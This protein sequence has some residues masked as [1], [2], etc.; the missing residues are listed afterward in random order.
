MDGA[1]MK[2]CSNC[3]LEYEDKFTFCRQCGSKLQEIIEHNFCPYCGNRIE[4]EDA[5]CP[6]CGNSVKE[7]ATNDINKTNENVGK[8]IQ[9]I[10][11]DWIKK[12]NPAN[13]KECDQIFNFIQYAKTVHE[14]SL[15]NERV[16]RAIALGEKLAVTDKTFYAII[17]TIYDELN[18]QT[19]AEKYYKM[20]DESNGVEQPQLLVH[21]ANEK[22]MTGVID[23]F[24]TE[25]KYGFIKDNNGKNVFFYIAQVQDVV[26]QKKLLKESTYVYH[27]KYIKGIDYKG[28]VAA[29]AIEMNENKG[30]I[31]DYNNKIGVGRIKTENKSFKFINKEIKNPLLLAAISFGEVDFADLEV[32]FSI[33]DFYDKKKGRIYKVACNIDSVKKFTKEE[34]EKFYKYGYISKKVATDLMETNV[35]CFA[36]IPYVPLKRYDAKLDEA[37]GK[38]TIKTNELSS[39][40][41]VIKTRSQKKTGDGFNSVTINDNSVRWAEHKSENV[42]KAI[43]LI[44]PKDAINPFL[45]L[46]KIRKYGMYFQKAQTCMLGKDSAGNIVTVDLKKAEDLFIAAIQADDHTESAIANLAGHVYIQTNN[47]TKGLQLLEAYG[48]LLTSEKLMNMRI[49]L[50]DKSG[51]TEALELILLDAIPKCSKVNTNWQYM[52]KLAGIYYKRKAWDKAVFWFERSLDFLNTNKDSFTQFENFR[53]YC[54]RFCAIAYYYSGNNDL[55]KEKGKELLSYKPED[56]IVQSIVDGKLIQ[57]E[58]DLIMNDLERLIED[59]QLEDDIVNAGD[60]D[61]ISPFL[62][63]VLE[64]VNL[65]ITFNKIKD[66]SSK[67]QNGVYIGSSNDVKQAV[68]SITNSVRRNKTVNAQILSEIYIGISRIIFDTRNNVSIISGSK[69]KIDDLKTYMG[70]Y[71]RY[72]ADA[73]VVK[74][75]A[76][77]TIR[78]LYIQSLKNL[79]DGD[80]G[81]ISAATNMLI[82][83]FFV[84]SDKLPAE[85]TAITN[86]DT[87]GKYNDDYYNESCISA[88]DFMIATFMLQ[89]KKEYVNRILNKVYRKSVLKNKLVETLNRITNQSFSVESMFDFENLWNSAKNVYYKNLNIIKK[90]ITDSINEFHMVESTRQHIQRI[91]ELLNVKVLWN[92]D[93]KILEKYLEL[94]HTLGAT[95]EKYTV[96]EKIEGFK[97][98]ESDIERLCAEVLESPTELSFDGVYLKLGELKAS[99]TND[100]DELY[101]S[102]VPEWEIALSN[103]SVYV[104]DNTVK[105]AIAFR[106]ADNKQ[107]ADAVRIELEG[108]A[109]AKF[110]QCE[111]HFTS[112]KSGEVQEYIAIFSLKNNVI[113]EGQ[114]EVTVNMHYRYHETVDSI[115]EFTITKILPITIIDKNNFIKIDNNYDKIVRQNSIFETPE[116]FKGRDELI[117]RICASMATQ[118][119]N[120]IKNKGVILWGQR[121]V[122]KNSVK[123]FLKK[124]IKDTYPNAYIIIDFNSVLKIS[125]F[126]D[127]LKTII[128]ITKNELRYH[129]TEIYQQLINDGVEFDVTQFTGQTDFVNFMHSFSLSIEKI[130]LTKKIVPLF[131]FDEFTRIYQWIEQG[132]LD[133]E[134]FAKFWKSFIQDYGVCA[135]MIAQDNMPLWKAKYQ[136]E[137]ACMNLE[138]VTFLDYK[139]T[140]E[141]ICEPC[142]IDKDLFTIDAVQL[143]YN[144]TKGSAFLI[145]IL[146]QAI[147]DYLNDNYMVKATK[148]IVQIVFE[149]EYIDKK[150]LLKNTDFESQIEDAAYVGNEGEEINYLNKELLKEIARKT[151]NSARIKKSELEFFNI[152]DK[153][154]AEKVLERLKERKIVDVEGGSYCMICMP[155]LKFYMLGE[156]GLLTR[157]VF[158]KLTR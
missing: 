64:K 2:I 48:H 52:T 108:S 56:M 47:I 80:G 129:Y 72:A 33:E 57:N 32:V 16:R 87:A 111:K 98:I 74:Y 143:I 131:F 151:V 50:I 142:K 135:I 13:K 29:D 156:Q 116:L 125:N 83:S 20:A 130:S 27:V 21:D 68:R 45:T 115:T 100:F 133:G 46:Q 43:S 96:E 84:K 14:Y 6:Y 81:N 40:Q 71:A 127:F 154:K 107:V 126:I 101:R 55:A 146:C 76:V 79:A 97:T 121:R 104:K 145:N 139:G 65:S 4:K 69:I 3:N 93:E 119:G 112:V 114:F 110:A 136:N 85:L 109:G 17:A 37:I 61:I 24:N 132:E 89:E 22:K 157:E 62:N 8:D 78:F 15:T 1:K 153:E 31:I 122:G 25:K 9:K 54:L 58:P 158:N 102:S 103:D 155:L 134:M 75:S 70:R 86:V 99:I 53:S 88:K 28:E 11:Q 91:E 7:E 73:L 59:M 49:Q 44:V 23:Y 30:V 63:H 141:L 113:D 12:V 67:I 149:K 77:D 147:I 26:L 120:V 66:I 138:N 38:R 60:N 94:L 18:D 118:D 144:W 123:D 34:I 117:N 150:E 92:Q 124:K 10:R 137:F 105:I 42:E 128:I 51:N 82:A 95:L 140:K 152:I 36:E 5:F 90:E 41:P 148:A 39:L 106:N 19:N 35:D